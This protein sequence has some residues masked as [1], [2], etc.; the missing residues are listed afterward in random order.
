MSLKRRARYTYEERCQA[1]RAIQNGGTVAEVCELLDIPTRCL[2]SWLSWYRGGGWD[3]LRSAPKSGRPKKITG[4]VLSWLYNAITEQDPRQFKMDFSLWTLNLIRALLKDK[5]GIIVSKSSISRLLKQLGL[6]PQKPIYKSYKRDPKEIEKYLDKTFPQLRE[7][8]RKIGAEIYFVDEAAV[9]SDNHR[10]R[11]W[12]VIGETPVV[13]DSGDRFGMRL[14]SAISA[15][16][17]MRFQ[18]IKTK[19]NSE[20]FCKFLKKLSQDIGKPLIIICD[21]ASYHKSKKT[22][23]FG[24]SLEQP[25]EIE[26]LPVYCPE[27]NPDEQVWNH[28]K[29][30]LGKM[31]IQTK[32][33]MNK[34]VL[35]IMR[36][37]QKNKKLVKSFFQ[38]ED[39][40]YASI[41]L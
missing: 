31:F 33:D 41:V 18:V 34:C 27:L 39:T 35:K 38:L 40:L 5:K 1:V 4:K 6:S 20:E 21:N 13:E 17:D 9:R 28:L 26:V 25:I 11:T 14:I 30:R 19:M 24:K 29:G 2:F 37:I 15:R 36:S 12:S 22:K 3:A 7:H 23:E 10:G 32:N 8:A 16:G